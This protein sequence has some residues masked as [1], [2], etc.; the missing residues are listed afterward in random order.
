MTTTVEILNAPSCI[1]ILRF[2]LALHGHCAFLSHLH[3]KGFT[4]LPFW[5]SSTSYSHHVGINIIIISLSLH[6]HLYIVPARWRNLG[7][8]DCKV[9]L[10]CCSDEQRPQI[11]RRHGHRTASD[12]AIE[13]FESILS[14]LWQCQTQ[15]DIKFRWH[16]IHI[17]S[18]YITFNTNP[19][20]CFSS[21]VLV[22]ALFLRILI[23]LEHTPLFSLTWIKVNFL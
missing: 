9:L 22:F 14:S 11:F 10:W 13:H 4:V 21:S 23:N 1:F 16:L 12:Q 3:V 18:T 15:M 5:L 7:L 20:G 17:N 19:C 8:Q 6:D 2:H